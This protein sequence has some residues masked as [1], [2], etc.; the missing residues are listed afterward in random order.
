[1]FF[2]IDNFDCLFNEQDD[3]FFLTER[4]ERSKKSKRGQR[5]FIRLSTSDWQR[6]LEHAKSEGITLDNVSVSSDIDIS[7]YWM[8]RKSHF[9]Y[10]Y[11]QNM[12]VLCITG[13]FNSKIASNRPSYDLLNFEGSKT[14]FWKTMGYLWNRLNSR[15]NGFK[16]SFGFVKHEKNI[17]TFREKYENQVWS[18]FPTMASSISLDEW[19]KAFEVAGL[20]KKLKD[21]EMFRNVLEIGSASCLLLSTLKKLDLIDSAIA[22]DLPFV[23][24]FGFAVATQ[25]YGNS[26]QIRLPNEIGRQQGHWLSFQTPKSPSI[27]RESIDLAINV[28]SFQEMETSQIKNYIELIDHAL[29]PGGMFLCVNRSQKVSNWEDYPWP[30]HY[31]TLLNG[32]TS[33]SRTASDVNWRT[34]TNFVVIQKPK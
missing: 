31:Q 23:I 16:D 32:E 18:L 27:R 12:Q 33:F 26:Q 22:L 34:A 21:G 8:N 25:S 11:N 19:L 17:R 28:S 10:I 24:P 15:A 1:M 30:S 7:E 20:I 3:H 2:E 14:I 9:A 13:Y 5:F 29:T 4:Q 6:I